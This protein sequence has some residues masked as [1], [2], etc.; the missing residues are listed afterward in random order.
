MMLFTIVEFVNV[1][2]DTVK[3]ENYV[4]ILMCLNYHFIIFYLYL[5]D[6]FK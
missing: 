5:F 4:L 1:L 6:I 3:S 2:V